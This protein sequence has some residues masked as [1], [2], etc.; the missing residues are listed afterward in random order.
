M[1]VGILMFSSTCVFAVSDRVGKFDAGFHVGGLVSDSGKVNAAAYYGGSVAYGV[2]DWFAVGVES[3]YGDSRTSFNIGGAD[4]K[5]LVS[6]IPLFV[7]LIFRYTKM[8]HDYVPYGVLGLGGLF[9]NIHGTGTLLSSNLKLDIDNSFAVK[10]GAGIDWF[11]TER[12]MLNFETSYVW[13]DAEANVTNLAGGST[14]DSARLDYW[15]VTGGFKY[16]FE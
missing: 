6:R 2:S 5:A 7:D 12:W 8:E 3:G 11:V 4:H 13:A 16:L 10:I 14:L 15:M 9:T 1:A